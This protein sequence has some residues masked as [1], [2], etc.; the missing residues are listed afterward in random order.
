MNKALLIALA[1]VAATPAMAWKPGESVPPALDKEY[2]ADLAQSKADAAKVIDLGGGRFRNLPPQAD[3][4]NPKKFWD[5]AAR[6]NGGGG[7]DGGSGG[8]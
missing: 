8:K 2:Q 7:G 4:R 6:Q 1:M 3:V 5:N